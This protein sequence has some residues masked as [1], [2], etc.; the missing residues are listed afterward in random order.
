LSPEIA[1][2]SILEKELLKRNEQLEEKVARLEKEIR[3]LRELRRLDLIKKYGPGSESLTG[4]QHLKDV[5]GYKLGTYKSAK[6]L[7]HYIFAEWRRLG[8]FAQRGGCGDSGR[9]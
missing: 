6:T 4:L 2:P 3:L 7:W 9:P 5:S 1:P 8:Q